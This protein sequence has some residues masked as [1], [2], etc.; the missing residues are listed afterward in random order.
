M[1]HALTYPQ[2]SG[3]PGACSAHVSVAI[4]ASGDLLSLDR[5][6]SV[7]STIIREQISQ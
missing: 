3:N 5:L 7:G 4:E 6:Y 2:T 1:K